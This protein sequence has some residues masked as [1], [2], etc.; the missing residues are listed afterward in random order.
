M[1]GILSPI[2]THIVQTSIAAVGEKEKLNRL[3]N[4]YR[5]MLRFVTGGLNMSEIKFG[6]ADLLI[7]R[8]DP[9][10]WKEAKSHYDFVLEYAA[11]GYLRSAATIG[12]AELA[13]RSDDKKDIDK[14]IEQAQK[15]YKHLASLVGPNDFYSIKCLVVEA[16]L[17][18]K[19]R[20]DDDFEEAAKLFEKAFSDELADPYFR[21]RAIVGYSEIYLYAQKKDVNKQI[22]LLHQAIDL[23]KDHPY[24]YFCIKAKLI[25]GEYIVQRMARYDK[26]RAT[27]IFMGII[28]SK[29]AETDLKLLA[30]VDLAE[31][32]T[33]K[34]AKSMLKEVLKTANLE[35]HIKEKAKF[36]DKN[37]KK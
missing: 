28:A 24:D 25:Q 26:S 32:S 37:L 2:L 8:D 17:R 9:G 21:A 16:E 3:I 20:S 23:L 13:I 10:D 12:M 4:K 33:Y 18:V 7:T 6:L 29:N 14:G 36:I 27:G 1:R 35:E 5:K 31:I 15:A 30:K 19:R 34:K 22:H 11:Y